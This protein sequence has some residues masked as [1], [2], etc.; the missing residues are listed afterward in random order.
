[1]SDSYYDALAPYYPFIYRDWEASIQRQAAALDGIIQAFFGDQIHTILDAACGIGTQSLGLAARGYQVTG[2]DLSDRAVE[3]ASEEADRR[4]L[5]I[6]FRVGDMRELWDAHR[7]RYDLVLACDNAVPHLLT[8]ADLLKAFRSFFRCARP[9]GGCLISVR[10]YTQKP[11]QGSHLNPRHIHPL[12]E[13][14]LIVFDVWDVT[15]DYY[16]MTT[17]LLEDKDGSEISVRVVR[18]GRYYC[19]PLEDLARVMKR[20]GFGGVQIVGEGYFQ[21][22]LI[23]N[24]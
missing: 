2:S 15:G 11:S 20:A 6:Q 7:A 22:V 5:D 17:Y 24:R 9:G 19:I 10:D 23:G 1:M 13:G 14:R 4:G 21:P 16:D 18:G 3:R 12:P 8:E